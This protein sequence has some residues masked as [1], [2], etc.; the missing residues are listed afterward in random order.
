MNNLKDLVGE[1]DDDNFGEEGA[2]S[3]SD[4]GEEEEGEEESDDDEDDEEG[5]EEEPDWEGADP[6][7]EPEQLPPEEEHSEEDPEQGNRPP[8]PFMRD[9]RALFDRWRAEAYA[10]PPR[11]PVPPR[12][13][14]WCTRPEPDKSH[15]VNERSS[16]SQQ[17]WQRMRC[18]TETCALALPRQRGGTS[19]AG[20]EAT[21]QRP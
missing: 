13:H 20:L 12:L 1:S 3:E 2:E 15:D 21:R 8:S 16:F 4:E 18:P 6:E 17:R 19:R 5:D 14:L 9:T 7:D 10:P 11:R